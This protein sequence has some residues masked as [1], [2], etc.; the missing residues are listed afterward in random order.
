M[1]TRTKP[2]ILNTSS[3]CLL[4]FLPVGGI[5]FCLPERDDYT[6]DLLSVL[7]EMSVAFANTKPS[8]SSLPSRLLEDHNRLPSAQIVAMPCVRCGCAFVNFWLSRGKDMIL[9]REGV[10]DPGVLEIGECSP[11][12]SM[13]RRA[14]RLQSDNLHNSLRV[15]KPVW[16]G[17]SHV[18]RE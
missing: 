17:Q 13:G 12:C 2:E 9:L 1:A 6:G 15:V 5:E 3:D 16:K 7:K 10:G 14:S 4:Q 8:P 11:Y 18:D